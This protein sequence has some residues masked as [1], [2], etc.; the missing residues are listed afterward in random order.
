MKL[1][2]Q[3]SERP[4]AD[5]PF[6]VSQQQIDQAY[7]AFDGLLTLPLD[8][9]KVGNYVINSSSTGTFGY[10]RRVSGSE[11]G[12]R[13]VSKDTKH[14]YHY[15]SNTRQACEASGYKKLPLEVREFCEKVDPLYWSVVSSFRDIFV[16]LYSEIPL[17]TQRSA[18]ELMPEFIDPTKLLNIH[19][20]LL[21]YERPHEDVKTIAE[22]HFDRSVFTLNLNETAP[23]LEIGFEADGSD[24]ADVSHRPGVAKFFTSAGWKQ[25][26]TDF[27]DCYPILRPAYHGVRNIG[28]YPSNSGPIVR[29]ALIGFANALNFVTD[30]HTSITRPEREHSELIAA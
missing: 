22:P 7:D 10:M 28:E 12:G 6:D 11:Q 27:T 5:V 24:L 16:Q 17:S 4:Y 18:P 14:A 29:R 19:L 15:G 30:V 23:G 20:R 1:Q 21:G 9:R 3:L 8:Y 26:P 13:Q 2:E 25:M